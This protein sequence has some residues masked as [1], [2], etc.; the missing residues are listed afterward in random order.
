MTEPFRT[1]RRVRFCD[2][3]L[4]GVMHFARY[5]EVLEEVEHEMWRS[6]GLSVHAIDGPDLIRW[7]RASASCEY[8][9]PLRFEEEMD[10]SLVITQVGDKSLSFRVDFVVD[11]MKAASASATTVC[12]EQVDGHFRSTP[13]PAMIREKIAPLVE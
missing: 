4:A 5:L 10:L 7:P 13:I 1:K 2:T 8:S 12:C 3:D 11:G 6:L 9:R